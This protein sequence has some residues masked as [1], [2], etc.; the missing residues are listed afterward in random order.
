MQSCP[1]MTS[2]NPSIFSDKNVSLVLFFPTFKPQKISPVLL[3]PSCHGSKLVARPYI[4]THVLNF[5]LGSLTK[6][7]TIGKT[8]ASISS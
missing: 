7:L 4:R 2:A 3:H 5:P 1:Y 8:M 6:N